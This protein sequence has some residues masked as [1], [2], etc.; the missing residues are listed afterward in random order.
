M[1]PTEAAQ[2]RGGLPCSEHLAQGHPDTASPPAPQTCWPSTASGSRR[3]CTPTWRR[4]GRP[5]LTAESTPGHGA[6][7]CSG[8]QGLVTLAWDYSRRRVQPD[9]GHSL[10]LPWQSDRGVTFFLNYLLRGLRGG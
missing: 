8:A 5:P 2:G 6:E 1:G 9:S 7:G 10:L 3:P 4:P